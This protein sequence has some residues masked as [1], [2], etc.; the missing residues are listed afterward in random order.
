[1]PFSRGFPTCRALGTKQ[2]R[3]SPS[4]ADNGSGRGPQPGPAERSLQGETRILAERRD[5][6]KKTGA[7]RRSCTRRERTLS[8]ANAAVLANAR[9]MGGFPSPVGPECIPRACPARKRGKRYPRR[10]TY[11]LPIN[12]KLYI[13]PGK[14]EPLRARPD[15]LSIREYVPREILQPTR[16]NPWRCR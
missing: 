16:G 3:T 6:K 14:N 7:N 4:T 9:C 15:Q 10:N 11:S 13:G 5:T 12:V 2:S 8:P 1:L